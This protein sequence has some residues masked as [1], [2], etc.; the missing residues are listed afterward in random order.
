MTG[1]SLSP[2]LRPLDALG[3]WGVEVVASLGR[4]GAFLVQALVVMVTPPFKFWAFVGRSLPASCL[5]LQ[6]LPAKVSVAT[7]C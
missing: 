5:A 2:A 4:F 7:V 3:G 6:S 1:R